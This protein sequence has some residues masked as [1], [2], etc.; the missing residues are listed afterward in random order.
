MDLSEPRTQQAI[1]AHGHEDTGLAHLVHEQR[2]R[3]RDDGAEADDRGDAGH[4]VLGEDVG[5][6]ICDAAQ[7]GV[8][9]HARRHQGHGRVDHGANAE[10]P[11]DAQRQI[12]AWIP[13]F[14]SR[15]AHRVK[16]NEGEEDDGRARL[17]ALESVGHKRM[18]VGGGDE[19][20]AKT[21]HRQQDDHLDDHHDAVGAGAFLDPDI[22]EPRDEHR[23]DHRQQVDG[24]GKASDC[25]SALEHFPVGKG[26]RAADEP[27]LGV[28]DHVQFFGQAQ[29]IHS[30][31]QLQRR[32]GIH[33]EPSGDVH[34]KDVRK[35]TARVVAP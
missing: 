28:R 11:K 35:K 19:L 4:L 13:A 8:M 27:G 26:G 9:H 18:P 29:A 22:A 3:G 34:V 17:D 7:F 23:D 30:R 20:D 24:D 32:A 2:S 15:G 31:P 33:G 14:F 21:H 6:G 10:G 5:Q 16:S 1:A 12:P 25:R